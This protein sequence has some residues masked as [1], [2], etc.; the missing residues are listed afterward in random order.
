M[1]VLIL[2]AS[3]GAGHNQAANNLKNEFLKNN[4][5]VE[6]IDLFKS[7]SN[8]FNS[9]IT[10]SYEILATR[11]PKVY[12]YFY[13]MVDKK[14]FNKYLLKKAFF[15]VEKRLKRILK[16][17]SPDIVIS[18]HPF[19][20]AVICSLK[21]K[22]EIDIPFIQIVTD[23]KAHYSY[24][25]DKVDAYIT[26]SDYTKDSLIEKGVDSNKIYAYGIPT[27]EEFRD[28]SEKKLK[29]F[30]EFNILIMG[31]SM[32]LS[33]MKD[34]LKILLESDLN[35]KITLIC[36]NNNKLYNELNLKF[37]D[38]ICGSKLKVLGFVNNV[39]EIM[40]K[41]DIIITKP[42]GLTT[43]EAINKTIPM[44]I[45]FAIPGQEEEN[46]RFMVDNNMAIEV[47]DVNLLP[48][49][50]EELMKNPNKYNEMV[51]N[52]KV[53]SSTYSVTG[54]VD[55]AMKLLEKNGE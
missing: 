1:R 9:I 49:Y 53:L 5:Q 52:M 20:V 32:G 44:V 37:N 13:N 15:V 41:S 50:I 30:N 25:D 8:I 3:T 33:P 22:K 23:F 16:N 18:T 24:V 12:G 11:I 4:A 31:G 47:T 2:S 45:P 6:I 42:G 54:I 40:E 36:G 26:A 38:Y 21:D 43:T 46:T 27:K 28:S 35:I 51:S 55:V 19:G 34:C 7:T 48:K 17:S 29:E 10:D 14:E 39:H